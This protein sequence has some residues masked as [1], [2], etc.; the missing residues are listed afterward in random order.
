M[1]LYTRDE[2]LKDLRDHVAEVT[3]KKVDG[4]RRTLR[5]TL[6]ANHLPPLTDNGHLDEMHQKEENKKTLVVW[7]KQAGGWK[8]F[9][10]DA[11]EYVQILDNF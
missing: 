5:C 1:S 11:V 4:T 3:F 9:H 7:D 6:M 10:V 2:L 8:S